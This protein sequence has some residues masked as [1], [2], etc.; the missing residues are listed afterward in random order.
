MAACGGVMGITG[1][2]MFVT[3]DEPTTL[4]HMLDHYDHVRKLVGV[5]HLGLGSDIDL[6]G[7]DDLPPEEQRSLPDPPRIF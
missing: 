6:D 7:Y 3:A 4:E 1:V 5:Q 2:R